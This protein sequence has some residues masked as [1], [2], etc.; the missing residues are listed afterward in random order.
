VSHS[1]LLRL[2]GDLRVIECRGSWFGEFFGRRLPELI[3]KADRERVA[4]FV[5]RAE[6]SRQLASCAYVSVDVDGPGLWDFRALALPDRRQFLLHATQV[7][8]SLLF[9]PTRCGALRL[10]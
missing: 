8:R 10:N 2:G 7:E 5:A 6:Q 4:R 9:G 1:V 3:C